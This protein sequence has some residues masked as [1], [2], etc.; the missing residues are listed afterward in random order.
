MTKCP[1]P[2]YIDTLYG[3][4]PTP[5]EDLPKTC[6][7]CGAPIEYA[8]EVCFVSTLSIEPESSDVMETQEL[9]F[10]PCQ[11]GVQF[12]GVHLISDAEKH[13]LTP[14]KDMLVGKSYMFDINTVPKEGVE[15]GKL[16]NWELGAS[17]ESEGKT[18]IVLEELIKTPEGRVKLA[19]MMAPVIGEIRNKKR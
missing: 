18:M 3:V 12:M 15:I 13:G 9:E 2:H 19:K 7:G 16:E 8:D 4:T 10:V 14:I 11:T 17:P 5:I 6:M 1:Y